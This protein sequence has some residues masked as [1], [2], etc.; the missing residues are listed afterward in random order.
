MR[1]FRLIRKFTEKKDSNFLM[2]QRELFADV[3]QNILKATAF[4]LSGSQAV[5]A[6]LMR[7]VIDALNHVVMLGA[8]KRSKSKPDENY[9]Y[10]TFY[11]GY[12]KFKNM[13]VLLPGVCFGISG[14]YNIIAPMI[15]LTSG[16]DIPHLTLNQMSL[17]V[18]FK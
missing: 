13:A 8:N 12:Q 17:G 2:I 15:T 3:I 10:G 4:Y 16:I 1:A 7:A 6:E 18:L 14:V 9:N 11:S 5:K